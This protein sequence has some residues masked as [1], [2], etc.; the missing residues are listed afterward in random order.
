MEGLIGI[1]ACGRCPAPGSSGS[2]GC[3]PGGEPRLDRL[4]VNHHGEQPAQLDAHHAPRRFQRFDNLLAKVVT[5]PRSDD[6]RQEGH[7][8]AD[9]PELLDRAT[10]EIHPNLDRG[11]P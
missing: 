4:P 9:H 3:A 6:R 2:A 11:H 10:P 1:A 7:P 5:T 8:M